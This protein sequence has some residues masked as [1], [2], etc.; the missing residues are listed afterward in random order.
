VRN[1][2]VGKRRVDFR[3]TRAGVEVISDG[4]VSVQVEQ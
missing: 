2:R 4:G 1:L 3:V